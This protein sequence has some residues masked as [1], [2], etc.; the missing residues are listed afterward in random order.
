MFETYAPNDYGACK[1]QEAAQRRTAEEEEEAT[2]A[3]AA[4]AVVVT[5][6]C[7]V[8]FTLPYKS[9]RIRSHSKYLNL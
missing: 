4:I 9:V 1:E 2:A 6:A 5:E 7:A 8:L 3:S